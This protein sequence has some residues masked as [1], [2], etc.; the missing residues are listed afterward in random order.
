MFGQI[1]IIFAALLFGEL[2]LALNCEIARR[3]LG[4]VHNGTTAAVVP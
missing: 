3:R 2:V 4:L 1:W